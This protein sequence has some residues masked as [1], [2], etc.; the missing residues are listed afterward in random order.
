VATLPAGQ[1]VLTSAAGLPE[2]AMA[3][4][5]VRLEDDGSVVVAD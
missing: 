1:T 5:V 4:R 2:G 3:E